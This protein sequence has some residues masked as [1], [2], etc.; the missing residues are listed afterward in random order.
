MAT[1]NVAELDNSG[2]SERV[3][4]AEGADFIP[5]QEKY[6]FHVTEGIDELHA[7]GRAQLLENYVKRRL[8]D[9]V[10]NEGADGDE[11]AHYAF[12][13]D[14]AAALRSAMGQEV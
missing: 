8:I 5:V 7:I 12:C 10:R 11:A 14:L 1:A 3:T 6:L 13:L 2:R 4:K 9:A